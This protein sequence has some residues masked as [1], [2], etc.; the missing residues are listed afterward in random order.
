MSPTLKHWLIGAMNVIL[1][2]AATA[3]G[4]LVAHTTFKQSLIIIGGAAIMSFSKWFLQNPLP[5]DAP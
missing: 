2:G 4:S 5:N 1:S 3:L